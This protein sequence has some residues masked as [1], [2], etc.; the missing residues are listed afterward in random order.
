MKRSRNL[1]YLLVAVSVGLLFTAV[2]IAPLTSLPHE[3][4]D[5]WNWAW[6]RLSSVSASSSPEHEV[7]AA[8]Q[9]AQEADVYGFSTE[10][11]QKTYPAPALI[12]VGRSSRKDTIYLEGQT[13]LTERQMSLALWTGG[14]NALTRKDGVEMRIDG[15]RTY[16]RTIGGEWQEMDDLSNAF[17]PGNDLMSYLAG[18]KNVREVGTETLSLSPEDGEVG[19]WGDGEKSPHLPTPLSPYLVFTR[20]AF[21]VDGPAFAEHLRDQLERQLREKGELPLGLTLDS[22][23]VYRGAT[24]QG[25]V[26]IDSR[27]L[28]LRLSVHLVYPPERNGERIEADIQTDFSHFARQMAAAPSFFENP[29]AWTASTL[30]LPHTAR[31][32][33]RVGRQAALVT[34]MLGLLLLLIIY[35]KS[36]KVYV[37]T[38]VAVIVSM[39]VTPLMQGHQAQTFSQRMAAQRAEHEQRQQEQE[40]AHEVQETLTGSDWDPHQDPLGVRN[41]QYAISN[42]Q[43]FGFAQDRSPISTIQSP[44]SNIQSQSSTCTDDEKNTDTDQDGLTDCDEKAEYDTDPTKKDTDGDGLQDGWEVL[45]LGT[46]PTAATGFDSDGDGIGDYLEVAGFEYRGKR[47]YSNPNGPDTDK[48]GRPDFTECPERATTDGATPDPATAC[49]DTDNDG[50]P[51]LFDLDSDG[52]GVPD[53]IDLSPETVLGNTTPFNRANP[54]NLNVQNLSHKPGQPNTY[55]PVF[56]DFQLRPTNPEHLTYALNVL[57]WP[58]GDED[59]QIMRRRGNDSTFA[60][61]LTAEQI[62][63]DPRAANGDMRLIPMLEVQMSGSNLPLAFTNPR[64]SL[65]LQGED[66]IDL[67]SGYQQWISATIGMQQD[68][69]NIRLTFDFQ[70]QTPV[71]KVGIYTGAC[72]TGGSE[73]Y[74]WENVSSGTYTISNRKLVTLADGE[75]FITLQAEGH[76]PACAPLGD[77]ANADTDNMIDPQP[78]RPYGVTVRDKDKVGNVLL[79]APL[80]IVPDESGGGRVAFSARVPYQPSGASLGNAQQVRVVW[81]VQ[82]IADRCKPL[83]EDFPYASDYWCMYESSWDLDNTQIVHAYSDDWYLTGL[84]VREDHGLNVSILWEDPAP[85]TP[86]HAPYGDWL[87]LLTRGLENAFVTGRDQDDDKIRDLGIYTQSDG[88]TVAEDTIARRFNSPLT[89]SVTLTDRLGIPLTATLHVKDFSYPTQDHVANIMVSETAKVLNDNFQSYTDIKPTLLFAREEM[90]R[91]V[92]LDMQ[93]FRAITG[94]TVTLDAGT[95]TAKRPLETIASLSWAPYRFRDGDWQSIPIEEYWDLLEASL[96]QRFQADQTL[97]VYG[98]YIVDGMVAVAQAQYLSLFQ[99]RAG[100]VAMNGQAI[101]QF[102]PQETDA[103]LTAYAQDVV[104]ASMDLV[105][106][107]TESIAESAM[108]AI[109]GLQDELDAI[110]AALSPEVAKRLASLATVPAKMR[111]LAVLGAIKGTPKAM[112]STL[113]DL[114]SKLSNKATRLKA[115]ESAVLGVAVVAIVTLYILASA[116]K[117]ETAALVLAITGKAIAFLTYT[118]QAMKTVYQAAKGTLGALSKAGT[119]AGIVGV[120]VVGVGFTALFIANM[121]IGNVKFGSIAMNAAFAQVIA[122]TVATAILFAINFIPVVGQVIAAILGAVDAL[123]FLICTAVPADK[124]AATEFGEWFCQGISGLLAT[125]IGWLIYGATIMVDLER[126]DRLVFGAFDYDFVDPDLGVSVGNEIQYTAPLTNTINLVKIPIDWKAASYAWQYTIDGEKNLKSSTFKYEW[127]TEQKDLHVD[128]D[129]KDLIDR[130]EQDATGHPWQPTGNDKEFYIAPTALSSGIPFSEAGINRKPSLYLSEGYAVPAQECFVVPNIINPMCAVTPYIPYLCLVPVCHIRAERGTSHMDIGQTL[131]FDVFPATLDDFY[132]PIGKDG[133]YSLAWGQT[134]DLTFGRQKDFDGDGLLNRMDRGSDPDDSRWDSDGDGLSDFFEFQNGSDPTLFDTDADG[135]SDAEEFRLDTDPNRKDTDG[136]GLTDKE[137]ADGW[138]FVYAFAPDGTQ[139]RTWVISDPLEPDTDNDG[140]SDFKEKVYGFNPRVWQD[141]TVLALQAGAWEAGAPRLLLRFEEAARSETF[142]DYSGYRNNAACSVGACPDAGRDGKYGAAVQFYGNEFLT[143]PRS[144]INALRNNFTVAA[145]INP[146]QLSGGRRIVATARTSSNNGFGFGTSGTDLRFTTFG[147]KD[148]TSTGIG[149]QTNQWQHVAAV[150]DGNNA[151]TFYVDGVNK[152]TIT[153]SAPAHADPDDAL[154]IGAT[155]SQGSATSSERFNGLID[156]VAVFDR[157]LSQTEIQ[158]MLLKARYNPN[159]SFVQVGDTL[160]YTATVGNKLYDRYAQGLFSLAA[161]DSSALS[162]VNVPPL[163]FVLQPLE[164]TAISGT[165]Q[166]AN[167]TASRAVSL[168]QVA[169]ALITNWREQSGFAEMWLPLDEPGTATTFQDHSGAM[170]PAN[171]ACTACPTSQESGYFDYSVRFD[172][173]QYIALPDTVRLGLKNSSFSVSAWINGSDFSGSGS[174]S[175]RAI[176]GTDT[177][178]TN[179]GL[180]LVIRNR[181]PYMGF[182]GN[183]LDSG[184]IIAA[185]AWYHLVFRYDKDTQEQSIYVNGELKKAET[186]HVAFQ[187][188]GTV[189]LGRALGGR[190]FKGRIDDVRVFKRALTPEEIRTL[191]GRPVLRLQF[192]EQ[193]RNI[194]QDTYFA[195][196]S[197]LGNDGECSWYACPG[198]TDGVFGQGAA[199][200]Y[201]NEYLRVDASPSLDLSDGQFTIA[202]WVYPLDQG[203]PVDPDCHFNQKTWRNIGW[204]GSPVSDWCVNWP[205]DSMDAVDSPRGTWLVNIEHDLYGAWS[206]CI[207]RR[208]TGNF[209]FQAGYYTFFYRFGGGAGVYL[210]GS[211][212]LLKPYLGVDELYEGSVRFHV[213]TSG[214]HEIKVEYQDCQGDDVFQFGWAP[215]HVQGI[216]GKNSGQSSAYPTLQTV[217]RKVRFG[218]GT[219]SEWYAVTT[220]D[221]VLIANAWNHVVLSFGPK[222]KQD[223][224][225]DQNQASLYVN[226]Q[227]VGD[228]GVGN[229]KPSSS[230]QDLYIG[231]SNYEGQVYID[232]FYVVDEADGSGAAE[233]YLTWG[234]HGGDK[235]CTTSGTPQEDCVWKGLGDESTVDVNTSM[236]VSGQDILEAW[237]DDPTHDDLLCDTSVSSSC[238]TG[239]QFSSSTPSMPVQVFDWEGDG[240]GGAEDHTHIN[241]YLGDS[242]HWAYRNPSIP[243]RGK[244]DELVI[245]KRPLTADEVQELYL[246]SAT[247]MHLRLDDPPGSQSFENAVDVSRQG[248]PFCTGDACPTAGVSGRINQ[249]ALFDGTSDV[250]TTTLTIS[251]TS[252]ADGATMMAWVYPK[253]TSSGYHMVVSTDNNG[254]DWT[255]ARNGGTWVAFNGTNEGSTGASVDVN[256]WQH[257]A[258]VFIPGQGTRFYKNGVRVKTDST[259][260]YDTSTGPVAIGNKSSGGNY[261]FDGVIDDVRIF[262]RPL[263]NDDIETIYKLAPVLQLH[264]DEQQGATTFIDAAGN[265]NG[266]CS[267]G[268]PCADV[269]LQNLTCTAQDDNDGDGGGSEFYIILAHDGTQERVWQGENITVRADPYPINETRS[270]C[271]PASI[272]VYEE[273]DGGANDDGLGSANINAANP[274][275]GSQKFW[276][277]SPGYSEVFL[278]W[279]VGP[280]SHPSSTCPKAGTA[281]QVSLAAEFDGVN[282]VISVPDSAALD[283][284]S[285]T[286]GAWVMPTAIITA[287]A[288]TLVHKG[289]NYAL[290]IPADGMQP[291][292]QASLARPTY[293]CSWPVDGVVGSVAP[294]IQNQWNHVMGTYDGQALKIY[295]NGYEQGSESVSGDACQNNHPLQ[296]GGQFAGRLDEVTLY[297]HALSPSEVRDIFLYQGKLVEERRSQTITID[298]DPPIS[299][300]R[301]Y[302]STFPYLANQDVVMHVEAQDQTSGVA[303]VELSVNGTWGSPPNRMDVPPCQD[304]TGGTAWCP[305]FIPTGEGAYTLQTRATDLVGNRETPAHTYTIYVDDTPPTVSTSLQDG[306]LVGAILHPTL[307]N[308]WMA[309]LSG[310]VS[311]PA[312]VGGAPGSSVA[313]DGVW[314]TLLDPQGGVAGRGAQMA[315]VADNTWSVDYALLG[316]MPTGR[317]T[318]TVQAKDKVGNEGTTNLGSIQVDATGSGAEL[319]A[320]SVP[321]TTISSRISINGLVSEL[322]LLSK[323]LLRLHLEEEAGAATFYDSSGYA[324]HG[325]CSGGTCPVAGQTGKYGRALQFDGADKV[326]RIP[327]SEINELGKNFSVAAWI[328]PS[329]LSGVQRIVAT[330]RT[331]SNNGFGFGASGTNLRFTT[332]GVKDY[333]L[334]GI[335]LQ[336]NR[337]THV[338]AVMDSNNAVTFYVDGVARGAI[339]HTASLNVDTDDVLLIGATTEAG[340]G[341]TTARFN[342]LIDEVMVFDRALSADEVRALAQA[343]AAGVDSVQFAFTP[344][345]PGSPFY[346]ETPP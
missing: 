214:V 233:V 20:Y 40:A 164:Q 89:P 76:S 288:Q 27:G 223:G 96:K 171:G 133:G 331:N 341:S 265:N 101:Y 152:G 64:T 151:V 79:Y 124:L 57:D 82:M 8:W 202:A 344:N 104:W 189:Y 297:D 39:V 184:F 294:L 198:S 61:G 212:I 345:L 200:F 14:G 197:G 271:G 336:T 150:M 23:A 224:T 299:A 227:R 273:D 240:S 213:S 86:S 58:S 330:A 156:E 324:N 11:V 309:P 87:W 72:T 68:G 276:T 83:A 283:L 62:K 128:E 162:Q 203:E 284:P 146:T 18:A 25:E 47:W 166:A 44:I 32:W 73:A 85:S 275:P 127:Q 55:Y 262:N 287:H 3:V 2:V 160:N 250:L 251:Q 66:Y 67:D 290:K 51:D 170:P 346:N 43:S 306:A 71:G 221:P 4:A 318:V 116:I 301:S 77:I 239:Y 235:I 337:W 229:R 311:D 252:S 226:N 320:R 217:G 45:R 204:S 142:A 41:T 1:R 179:K 303:L 175:D 143:I 210:D 126:E 52:D 339:A 308:T 279:D 315:T 208:Y 65:Q 118:Y 236:I 211:L 178:A 196:A 304:A 234:G 334:T 132:Q 144:Q 153:H 42:I 310:T 114:F 259:I 248:N 121:V 138:E 188:D 74:R 31:E 161:T 131:T 176:L 105:S 243:F 242:S 266:T 314:V 222:Y 269:T 117:N 291:I 103:E 95:G 115:A 238:T 17:A 145:W 63:A 278:N 56:V 201:G 113:K 59:G 159:D 33:Q 286:V 19:G 228:W 154:L 219:G 141:P 26:W 148:Y 285:F 209:R 267:L 296:I 5:A 167:V 98:D 125:G 9:R 295:V 88:I 75:H 183:D 312:L 37:A 157:A 163:T 338:A 195:D 173:S 216:L 97:D 205:Q 317:Y 49:R 230:A 300:L 332:F 298:N 50:A 289:A 69:A 100:L 292:L 333:T 54:F 38:V 158:N 326:V 78:L 247:A 249:A 21:D 325:T 129:G 263:S 109:K 99:G 155:T 149:L 277:W 193:H 140:L 102:Q 319:D 16:G 264:L 13:N 135:L 93:D 328:N 53:K 35:R 340:S 245:Y 199:Y 313:P 260:A 60:D 92:S 108:E 134:G 7:Q 194:Y 206:P 254:W 218:F 46:D 191:Y 305:T 207:S 302:T 256:K 34:G 343:Q 186:G 327:H 246:S 106:K 187:G 342:G 268:A 137:E 24:G 119:I 323:T 182:Y 165:V 261:Y 281:G 6:G 84:S 253:S 282:D 232:R 172:G 181:K 321:T 255:L 237:E 280:A 192:E 110:F 215:P 147:V 80:N 293:G 123:I 136:D 272:S 307:Q 185:N 28:P 241:L 274:G 112:G 29:V 81:L 180:H 107:L 10:I 48:D 329:Q 36:K 139:L 225:F 168:T 122:T 30:G 15:D 335:G 244:M 90:Y 258:A 190:G 91:V 94:A 257:I 231:R 130:N 22:S 316:A 177:M 120:I 70:G 220:T 322:P 174:A 169:S 270:F 12:N 111:F